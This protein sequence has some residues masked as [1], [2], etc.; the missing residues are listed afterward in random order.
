MKGGAA[1]LLNPEMETPGGTWGVAADKARPEP[2]PPE[3]SIEL[4]AE[5]AGAKP[6]CWKLLAG[7][8][9][10]CGLWNV[11]QGVQCSSSDARSLA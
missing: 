2:P 7:F 6:T 9:E 1:R 4:E 5:V 11:V 3:T 10:C 8:D